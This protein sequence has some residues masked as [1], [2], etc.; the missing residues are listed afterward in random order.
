MWDDET[1]LSLL[2]EIG[3]DSPEIKSFGETGLRP[4]PD[5]PWREA[6]TLYVEAVKS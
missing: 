3:F 6:E 2:R 4:V 1:L 5:R